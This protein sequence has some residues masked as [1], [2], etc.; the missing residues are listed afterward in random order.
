MLYHVVT[1]SKFKLTM[2]PHYQ[3]KLKIT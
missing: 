2:S 1:D 3:I